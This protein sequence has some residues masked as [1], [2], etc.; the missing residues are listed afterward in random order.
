MVAPACLGPFFPFSGPRRARPFVVGRP[1]PLFEGSL[2]WRTSTR[3]PRRRDGPERTL[4]SR[5]RRSESGSHAPSYSPLG[6]PAES[7]RP[8]PAGAIVR[9]PAV[10]GTGI[11]RPPHTFPDSPER[12]GR[13]RP[14]RRARTGDARR[15]P[16]APAATCE[17]ACELSP[18]VLY[19]TTRAAACGN[20]AAALTTTGAEAPARRGRTSTTGS[21][22]NSPRWRGIRPASNSSSSPTPRRRRGR[23]CGSG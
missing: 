8:I 12:M 3:A 9:T 23:R 2:R 15:P 1:R 16:L 20:T 21:T 5:A 10:P 6:L 17:L 18:G 11:D 13:P 7:A 22:P 14:R 4:R 19:L